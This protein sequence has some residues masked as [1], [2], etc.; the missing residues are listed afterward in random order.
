MDYKSKIQKYKNKY[1]LINQ[2]GG[3]VKIGDLVQYYDIPIYY[4]VIEN[5][6]GST[7]RIQNG[8]ILRHLDDHV[9]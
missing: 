3:R 6:E 7:F 5:N 1:N 2:Y 9:S 8:A 4:K